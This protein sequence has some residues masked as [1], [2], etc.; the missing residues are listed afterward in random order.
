MLFWNDNIGKTKDLLPF[1]S[2]KMLVKQL[3]RKE[4]ISYENDHSGE[5]NSAKSLKTFI[6]GKRMKLKQEE[7]HHVEIPLKG[8]D[9]Q[10]EY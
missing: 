10:K 6:E 2:F 8:K 5:S 9:A 4:N 1:N 7:K 3:N